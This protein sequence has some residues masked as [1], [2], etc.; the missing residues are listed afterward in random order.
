MQVKSNS[1]MNLYMANTQAPTRDKTYTELLEAESHV[2]GDEAGLAE[3]ILVGLQIEDQQELIKKK[4]SDDNLK[5]N[6]SSLVQLLQTWRCQQH[7]LFP[8]L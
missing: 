2:G 1:K 5:S 7:L 4:K 3:F 8:L 6:R